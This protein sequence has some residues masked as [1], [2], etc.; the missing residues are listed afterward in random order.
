M[1]QKLAFASMKMGN[2]SCTE[3]AA[4]DLGKPPI[5]GSRRSGASRQS[6]SEIGAKRS[7]PTIYL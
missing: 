7:E 3:G 2:P 1:R 6:I 4:G 5:L